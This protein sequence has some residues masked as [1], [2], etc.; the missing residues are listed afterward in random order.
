MSERTWRVIHISCGGVLFYWSGP[1]PAVGFDTYEEV[2]EP[3]D[4]AWEMP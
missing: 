3:I 4:N 1:D 2:L